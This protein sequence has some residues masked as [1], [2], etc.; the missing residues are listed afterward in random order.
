MKFL[1]KPVKQH[2]HRNLTLEIAP[3]DELFP[4]RILHGQDDY[5]PKETGGMKRPVIDA[6]NTIK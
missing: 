3:R 2:Q 6:P 5:N 1:T 4:S